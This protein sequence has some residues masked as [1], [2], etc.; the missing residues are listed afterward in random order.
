MDDVVS[1]ILGGG[2]G[3]RLWPLTRERAK[4]AV[5]VGGKFRLIDIPI[6]NSLHAGID[7]IFVLT[8]FNTASLHR[9]IAQTYRFDVFSEGFVNILAAEQNL[10]NRD[11]YQG[12]A[13]AVRQNLRRLES[14]RPRDVLILSGD[15]LYLMDLDGFVE[16][17]RQSQADFTVAVKPVSPQ[18]APAL[19]IM[20]LD[21]TGRIVEFVEKPKDP[22]VIDELTLDT[23]TIDRLDLDA[24]PGTLLASMGI[25]TFRHDVLDDL[26]RGTDA[27]DFG[28]EV[29][30]RAL[31]SHRVMGFVHNG[32]WRDIGTIGAFHEA[33]LE[34]TDRVPQLNLYSRDRPVYTHPRFLPGC[35]V[36]RCDVHRSILCDGSIV[37]ESR[38]QRSVVGIRGVVR[39]GAALEETV[40]MGATDFEDDPG[41]RLPLGVGRHSTI[42]RAILD[43]NCR[44]GDGCR[45]VNEQG[46]DEAE[47]EGWCIRDGVIVVNRGAQIPPGTVV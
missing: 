12:T 39:E 14:I 25:Y 8:Q 47:G 3:Q 19:G 5:P 26:L 29:I 20:R 44:I 13:D 17:H 46:V 22:A 30:P 1:A 35:K 34:L 21:G 11:W 7:K 9:H 23:D 40:F 16:S 31:E 33:N 6:S 37:S 24:E 42:R 27:T 43:L 28:R 2:Q 38:I 4:P 36:N 15:Q 18:E 10:E 32:Y 41:D 45:L